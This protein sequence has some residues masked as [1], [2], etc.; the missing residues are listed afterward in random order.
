M[1]STYIRKYG[2]EGHDLED[3]LIKPSR[4][5]SMVDN[6]VSDVPIEELQKYS[7]AELAEFA[8]R[9]AKQHHEDENFKQPET[10]KQYLEALVECMVEK[11]ISK[12]TIDILKI[13]LLWED[14][15]HYYQLLAECYA[16]EKNYVEAARNATEACDR[17]PYS[18]ASISN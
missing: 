12:E 8:A 13:L 14:C 18:Y 7:K 1:L 5:S 3:S 2:K 9:V 17:A 10:C 4:A 15:A 11:E 16:L 6:E